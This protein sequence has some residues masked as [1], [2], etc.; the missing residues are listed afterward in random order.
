M[1]CCTTFATAAQS[2]L[3]LRMCIPLQ[4]LHFLLHGLLQQLQENALVSLSC[5]GARAAI[6]A[7]SS[8][9]CAGA[10][11]VASSAAAQVA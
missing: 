5:I 9:L 8:L 11:F 1:G 7:G 4:V 10:A 2:P 3:L 6:E